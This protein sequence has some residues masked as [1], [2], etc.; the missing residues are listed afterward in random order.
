M[1]KIKIALLTLFSFILFSNFQCESD[2]GEDTGE[3]SYL[4]YGT[5]FGECLGYCVR[6]I[7]VSG[8]G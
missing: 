5:S 8:V 2:Y 4:S 1:N 6:E 3:V 7:I